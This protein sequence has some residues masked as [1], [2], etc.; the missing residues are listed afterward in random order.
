MA[1]FY[2]LP[3]RA[4]LDGALGELLDRFL[5]GLPLPADTWDAIADRLAS[6]AGWPADVFLVPRDDLPEGEPVAEA[7]AAGFGAEPGDRVIE[8]GVRPGPRVWTVEPGSVSV[9]A[10]A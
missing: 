8:V 3:P 7:L 2:L 6:A 5:P 4:T 1:S 10:R 9:P